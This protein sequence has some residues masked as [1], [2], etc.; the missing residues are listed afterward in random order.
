MGNGPKVLLSGSAIGYYGASDGRDL[1]GPSVL[2][3][4]RREAVRQVV[5]R[6]VAVAGEEFNRHPQLLL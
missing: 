1:D 6:G 2:G 3:G 5:H 4:D